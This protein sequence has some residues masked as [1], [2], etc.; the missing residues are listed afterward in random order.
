MR[1]LIQILLSVTAL[2]VGTSACGTALE[3]RGH[4]A[5]AA[6][7]AEDQYADVITQVGGRYVTVTS[8]IDNPSTDPH[9]FESSPS[10]AA[11]IS[12]ARL[13]V[14]NGLGYDAFMSRIE[15]GAPN[16]DR[17]VVDVQ[18][19]LGLPDSS[20]N[21]HLW[22]GENTMLDLAAHVDAILSAFRPRLAMYFHAREARFDRSLGPWFR[23][24]DR[25]R[26][27][28]AGT[29]VAATEP[30]ANLLLSA[31]GLHNVTPQSFQLD[32]MNGIDPAP[33]AISLMDGLISQRKVKVL[34]Y[35]R[36]VADSLT[37]TVRRLAL[38]H[39][40]PI[41]GVDETM[42]P[43][44]TYGRWMLDTTIALERALERAR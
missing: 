35:N 29:A 33:Q 20:Q 43:R 30:V 21:P 31:A 15:A 32:V 36:Q 16:P 34:V 37:D 14:Q 25:I 8:I 28:F 4:G 1:S 27:R 23:E 41:V 17:R 10:V 11:A 38:S 24:L 9:A 6:V 2:A 26:H 39:G 44:I 13:V 19:L 5:I 42:P 18:R 7:G 40:V 12:D 3:V 22:Y